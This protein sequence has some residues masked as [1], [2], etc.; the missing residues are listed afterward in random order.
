MREFNWF[1][2]LTEDS[3][4]PSTPLFW[5]TVHWLA[6][7]GA[8]LSPPPVELPAPSLG[9]QILELKREV[10]LKTPTMMM[11]VISSE[12]DDQQG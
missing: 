11:A 4:D 6:K 2:Q 10:A 3:T 5:E 12:L 9:V 7:Q 8:D 1:A